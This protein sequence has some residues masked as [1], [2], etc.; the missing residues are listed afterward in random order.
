MSLYCIRS[1]LSE[2]LSD[3]RDVSS[4]EVLMNY[5]QSL[6]SEVEARSRSTLECIEMGKT[7][8]AVRN[9]AAEEVRDYL[10]IDKSAHCCRRKHNASGQTEIILQE[11]KRENQKKLFRK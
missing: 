1:E 2:I 10:V 6:K 9:P 3:S 4:V 8:L 11:L 5:H 7:L